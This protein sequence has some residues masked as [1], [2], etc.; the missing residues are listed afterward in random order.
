MNSLSLTY[1][2]GWFVLL[3][4]LA[5]PG[6]LIVSRVTAAIRHSRLAQ[7]WPTARGTV[8]A[9]HVETISYR[10]GRR[11][12]LGLRRVSRVYQPIIAY[13]YVVDGQTY[14]GSRYQYSWPGDWAT[15]KREVAEAIIGEHPIGKAVA[16]HYDPTDPS[17][18]CLEIAASQAG[19]QAV[20]VFGWFLLVAAAALFAFGVYTA[21]RGGLNRYQAASIRSGPALLPV[22]TSQIRAVLENDLG[23][24][25]QA[26]LTPGSSGIQVSY[27]GWT[28]QPTSGDPLPTVDVWSRRDEPEKTDLVWV[29]TGWPL[30]G[31]DQA[32]LTGAAASAVA[33]ADAGAVREWVSTALPTLRQA[34][35]NAETVIGDVRLRLDLRSETRC[36]L[37][38]GSSQ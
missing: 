31:V 9:A 23:L 4:V 33:A 16:V 10:T 20:R 15:N 24:A 8:T 14:Q 22:A 38:I 3:L 21:A 34:G 30:Q 29:V 36:N 2:L 5:V 1:L 7:T 12:L 28:C 18:A 26:G 25:C 19:M 6:Y 13:T 27:Q 32:V 35:D 37:T 11:G 17:Q